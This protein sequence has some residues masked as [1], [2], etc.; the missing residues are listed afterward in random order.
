[1][2]RVSVLVSERMLDP[3]A[4]SLGLIPE[5][6]MEPIDPAPLDLMAHAASTNSPLYV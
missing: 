2:D 5:P 1:M 4:G 3:V 6:D